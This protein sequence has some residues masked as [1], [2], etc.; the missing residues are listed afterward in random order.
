MGV[1]KNRGTPK[2]SIL[3]GFSL[4]NHPFWGFPPYF[5]VDTYIYIYIPGLG[6]VVHGFEDPKAQ[7][8]SRHHEDFGFSQRQLQ[9][10]DIRDIR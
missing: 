8:A 2:A 6:S 9:G 3:I 10:S 1:S 5:W 4:I 7:R